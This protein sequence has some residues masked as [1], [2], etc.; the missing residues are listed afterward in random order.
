[1]S[2][3]EVRDNYY[4]VDS[5]THDH[6]PIAS[7]Q[8]QSDVEDWLAKSSKNKIEVIPMGVSSYMSDLEKARHQR[9]YGRQK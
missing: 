6:K 5:K 9:K 4:H 8:M 3:R 1:M 2:L 7:K